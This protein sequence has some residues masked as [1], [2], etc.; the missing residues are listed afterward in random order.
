MTDAELSDLGLSRIDALPALLDAASSAPP[1]ANRS[2]ETKLLKLA[3]WMRGD[4][5]DDFTSA[6]E[7]MLFDDEL[8]TST[9]LMCLLHM[10]RPIALDYLFGDLVTPRPDLHK[11]LI[12][13]RYWHVFRRFIDTSELTLWLWGDPEAQAFQLEAMKQWYAANRWK[14]CLLYTSPSPRDQRGS[15]MPS[16]A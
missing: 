13:E 9:V 7:A 16:S 15:R 10:K 3:L 5:G 4:L 2:A 6:A 1:S 14:I 11:L 8:P 12:Q